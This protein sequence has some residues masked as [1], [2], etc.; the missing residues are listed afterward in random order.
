MVDGTGGTH[1]VVNGAVV[2]GMVQYPPTQHPHNTS[3][4]T[5]VKNNLRHQETGVKR[6]CLIT[7]G[8]YLTCI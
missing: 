1:G 6:F 2:Q 4:I 5:I 8:D 3:G 7:T